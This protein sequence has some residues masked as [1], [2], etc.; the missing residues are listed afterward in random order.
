M[1][2]EVRENGAP[3]MPAASKT[4]Q[5]IVLDIAREIASAKLVT[6]GWTDYITLTKNGRSYRWCNGSI[7]ESFEEAGDELRF[8]GRHFLLE[9]LVDLFR[10]AQ[11]CLHVLADVFFADD[12]R[13]F[14]LVNELGRLLTRAAKDQRAFCSM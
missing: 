7:A 6:Q 1:M 4:G 11:C 8:C 12:L 14:R 13:E 5:V 3:D 10:S 9:P 2:R